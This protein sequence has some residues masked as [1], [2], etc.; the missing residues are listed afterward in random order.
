MRHLLSKLIAPAV[1]ALAA[2]V[3][4]GAALLAVNWIESHTRQAVRAAL[5]DRGIPWANVRADGMLMHLSGTAPDEAARFHALAAAGSVVDSTNLIDDIEVAAPTPLDGPRFS[6]ELLRNDTGISV[7]GLIP[8]KSRTEDLAAELAR[9]AGRL[10]VTD[11]MDSADDA[12]PPGWNAAL[13]FGLIALDRLKRSKISITANRVAVTAISDSPQDKARLER[14][15]RAAAPKGLDLAL[16]ISAP[17][18]TI[19]PFTL[20]FLMDE[21]GARFDACAADTEGAAAL[22]LAAAREAGAPDDA[23]CTLGLGAPS[24]DWGTAAAGGIAALAELGGGSLTFSDTDVTLVAAAGTETALF[25]RVSGTLKADLPEAFTLHTVLPAPVKT[26]G[27]APGPAEFVATLSPEGLVQMRGRVTDQMVRDATESYARSRFG[28]EHVHSA[29]RLDPALPEGWPMRVLAGLEALSQLRNGSAVVQPDFV[30]INGLTE[31]ETARAR[32]AQILSDRLGDAQNFGL[33]ITYRKPPETPG[34]A[35]ADPAACVEQIGAVLAETKITFDPGSA[36]IDGASLRVVDQIA[37]I[38]RG[39]PRARMEIAGYTDSQG[40]DE[41]NLRLSQARANA[42][43][44]ALM[45]RRILVGNLTAKGYGE[46]NPVAGNDTE[47]GRE[48]NRRIEFHLIEDAD[49]D[50]PQAE[51]T[52]AQATDTG[53]ETT[54]EAEGEAE[55]EDETGTEPQDDIGAETG[56]ETGVDDTA[57]DAEDPADAGEEDQIDGQD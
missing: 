53:D 37:D 48:A 9:I 50:A 45:A 26:D 41:M 19:A 40:R 44:D 11:M 43:V 52:E 3:C 2:A 57:R 17:R 13:D 18:P 21:A 6:V 34:A 47:E 49:P 20:R 39:C 15:L 16:D 51:D 24:A 42:V 12:A 32:V 7:I 8:R 54:S 38:L 27:A 14:E 56:P 23:T 29:L 25:D 46:D 10:P 5:T 4:L 55:G 1:F 31:D 36:T 28:G 33:Q 22:I 30:Q 35:L